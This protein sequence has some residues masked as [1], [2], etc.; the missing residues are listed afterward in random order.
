MASD[1]EKL[2]NGVQT[3]AV[4]CN[5]WGDSGKG[6]YSDFFA[7]TWADV[8]AR[9]TGGN[10]AGHTVVINGKK[11]IFHLLPSGIIYDKD[12]KVNV[13]GN[14]MVIDLKVLGQELDELDAESIT[15]NN[16]M[17]SEDAQLILPHHVS[18]DQKKNASQKKGGIGSTGRG[19]GPCYTDKYI[20]GAGLNVR[21]IFN[22]DKMHKRLKKAE[23][24][25]P[26][27]DIDR[28]IS[29]IVP[30]AE[31]IKPFV[32]DTIT[33]MHKFY[34]DGKKIAL[35]GAQGLLLSIEFGTEPYVTSS[36]CSLNGTATG[37]GLS[38]KAIDLPLGIVKFPYMT[39]VGAGPFPS[40]FGGFKSEE[41]C[42]SGLEHDI[43]VELKQA[44]VPFE[45]VE[46]KNPKYDHH[47]PKIIEMMN[48]S[49]P[50]MKGVGIRLAGEEYGA[51]TGRP[52]RTGWTD[53][54]ALKYAVGIN[55]P[56]VIL[57]KPDVL[58]G[59]ETIN[60]VD[61]YSIGDFTRDSDKLRSTKVHRKQFPGFDNDI[62]GIRDYQELPPG[63]KM[64][65]SYMYEKTGADVKMV[66]V[67][68]EPQETIIC[69]TIY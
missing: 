24:F 65:I 4:I 39:R 69:N 20:R 61:E 29:E 33:E 40:E 5:Q 45:P 57:T 27:V 59:A 2:T 66:S 55:G 62:S 56:N 21:D 15:Y 31:R 12:G 38:A 1:L 26:D 43:R 52:R 54:V 44:G 42:A 48:S 30:L 68:P 13:L 32:R 22:V 9:G 37:V 49:N 46:G 53:L 47:H 6:K 35:E 60:L 50:F 14:G 63:L 3:L 10:N 18:R 11:R 23:S 64:A 16:L 51:T 41:Y 34:A 7:S 19:I 8:I 58:Q 36:D 67:G 28:I 17:I 25:Y